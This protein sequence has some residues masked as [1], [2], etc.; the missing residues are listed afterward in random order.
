MSPCFL[1]GKMSKNHRK[2][3]DSQLVENPGEAMI[4]KKLFLFMLY[5]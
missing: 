2:N 1:V 4:S 5:I 3:R